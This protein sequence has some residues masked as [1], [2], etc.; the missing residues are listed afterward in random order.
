MRAD[1]IARRYARA[2][3]ELADQQGALDAVAAALASAAALL[4]DER[5]A[6]VLTGPVP[7]EQKHQLLRA[8]S[9]NLGAPPIFRDLLLLL[10]DHH[11]ID[12]LGAI[13][14]VFDALVD[15]RRGRIRAHV[16]SATPLPN[17]LLAEVTRVFGE[18]TRKDILADVT[19][20]PALLAGIV[21][22]IGGRVYD[23]SL[24]TQLGKLRQQMAE[25]S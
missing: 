10:A 9:D 18:V 21:V 1:A 12:H 17:D 24:R 13:R 25:G 4:E 5:T 6:T 8:I 22:E 19:V 23:G 14:A 7:R 20:D 16:R 2:I 15:Q 3:F 11:R